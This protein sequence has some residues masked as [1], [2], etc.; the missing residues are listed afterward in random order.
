MRAGDRFAG[1]GGF[2]RGAAQAAGRRDRLVNGVGAPPRQV[3]RLLSE[4][5]FHVRGQGWDAEP[6]LLAQ[7]GG[8]DGAAA[9]GAHHPQTA[10][11][12]PVWAPSLLAVRQG[13]S[14]TC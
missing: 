11:R 7:V 12:P 5:P 4:V 2:A 8:E 13:N 14:T 10:I 6:Q 1:W 3:R 9:T